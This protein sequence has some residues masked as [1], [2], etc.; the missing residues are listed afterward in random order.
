LT[1]RISKKLSDNLIAFPLARSASH[2]SK[3]PPKPYSAFAI[4]LFQRADELNVGGDD[5]TVTL[6]D[7][8]DTALPFGVLDDRVQVTVTTIHSNCSFV[9]IFKSLIA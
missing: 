2:K 4:P 6:P 9:L 5:F 7:N 8:T 1:S 3:K